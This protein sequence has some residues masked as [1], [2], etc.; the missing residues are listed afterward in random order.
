MKQLQET[1]ELNTTFDIMITPI[2]LTSEEG[3]PLYVNRAFQSQIG[4]STEDVPNRNS[5]FKNAYPEPEYRT[6]I[7]KSW[8]NCF[9][10]A[11]KERV[12]PAKVTSE[13][14]CADGVSRWFEVYIQALGNKYVATFLNIDEMKRRSDRFL[15]KVQQN[16]MMLSIV[17][18]D[19]RSPLG[20]IKQIVDGYENLNLSEQ[21][22]ACLLPKINTQ[23]DHVFNILNA[24]LM[25]PGGNTGGF[26][27]QPELIG[28][29]KFFSKYT[30]YY[31]ERLV[32]KNISLILN[33]TDDVE[34]NYDRCI[35]DVICR[36]LLDNAIK[37][38]AK[39]GEIIISFKKI[40]GGT[41]LLIQDTGIG[42]AR[43]QVERIRDNQESRKANR[44][45]RDGFGLGLLLAK[46]ILEKHNGCLSVL[47]ELGKGTSFVIDIQ[48][49][50]MQL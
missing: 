25:R 44:Q 13:I 5:W 43:Q 1:I 16:E 7:A 6:M 30:I 2:M 14:Y 41:Q 24:I 49:G 48:D 20:V 23:V 19:V 32:S 12:L 35:L 9:E 36:N 28:L 10:T 37:Y 46:Q 11:L 8:N 15:D 47:S 38:T 50:A 33:L 45:V 18:H 26:T 22:V 39:N 3:A 21:D 42:M 29:K 34:L 27:A 40:A 4:Y 17:A 31:K